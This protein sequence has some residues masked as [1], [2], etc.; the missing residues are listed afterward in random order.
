MS[1]RSRHVHLTCI[2]H[3]LRVLHEGSGTQGYRFVWAALLSEGLQVTRG[4]VQAAMLSIFGPRAM[5]TRQPAIRRV[6]DVG[7][8]NA[9]W[10]MDGH[11]KLIR[12]KFVIHAA[13]DGFSRVITFIHCSDNN[14]ADTVLEQFRK[15][16]A[17]WGWPDRV[18]VDYGGENL[19]VRALMLEQPGEVESKM[20]S[21]LD[22][23]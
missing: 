18:R 1:S 23:N 19:G 5:R 8:A 13:I 22:I 21:L 16:T 6:Y 12:W 15:G 17:N 3:C 20:R 11:H 4:Q 9:L 7:W 10:H 14:R 2:Q